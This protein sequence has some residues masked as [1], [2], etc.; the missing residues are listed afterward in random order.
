MNNFVGD[1]N[2]TLLWDI[3]QEENGMIN[4]RFNNEMKRRIWV[5]FKTNI[6]D[7]YT[8]EQNNCRSLLE[9]NKKYISMIVN[10]IDKL[11]NDLIKNDP[12]KTD[13]LKNDNNYKRQLITIED[14]QTNNIKNFENDLNT[15]KANFEEIM[16]VPKP[17]VPNFAIKTDELPLKET[18]KLIQEIIKTR[19]YEIDQVYKKNDNMQL[20]NTNSKVSVSD[21]VKYININEEI[22]PPI[23]SEIIDLDKVIKKDKHISWKDDTIHNNLFAKLKKTGNPYSTEDMSLINDKVDRLHSKIDYL[24]EQINI[25]MSK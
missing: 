6:N 11:K 8:R 25:L 18:D 17:P 21:N 13:P 4:G 24:I 20:N 19:N 15:R 7:F 1:E 16:T 3:I 23:T 22:N 2:V 14:I 9:L 10:Y 5:T 12:V